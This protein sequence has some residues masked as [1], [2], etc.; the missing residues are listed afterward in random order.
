MLHRHS[1]PSGGS[2]CIYTACMPTPVIAVVV[3][4]LDDAIL[5]TRCLT[6]LRSQSRP[7]DLVIVADNGST[8]ASAAVA[9]AHNARVVKEPRRGITWAAARGYDAAARLGADIIVRTDADAHFPPDHLATLESLWHC[10]PPSTVGITGPA[11]F[12]DTPA[13]VS[14]SY[15]GAYRYSVGSALGHP[16]LFGTNCSFRAGWWVSVRGGVD[17]ADTRA[18][19]DIQ[20]S[21]AVRPGET[22]LFA[23]QLVVGMDARALRGWRQLVARFSRGWHSMVRG[24]AVSPPWRRLP[25]R[26]VAAAL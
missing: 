13:A 17:L 6:S 12:D 3:P 21:F 5:L 16:P 25:Q 15:L 11:L 19:D 20:L 8:D 23:P 2:F 26:W 1:L 9:R 14:R 18:H 7:A 10:A 4:C 24:F 22:V